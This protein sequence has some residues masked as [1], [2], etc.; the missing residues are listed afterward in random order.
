[1]ADQRLKS[2]AHSDL[3]KSLAVGW[4]FLNHWYCTEMLQNL[5]KNVRISMKP[6]CTQVYQEIWVGM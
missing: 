3:S 6:Y 5:I 4:G 2:S 1:M